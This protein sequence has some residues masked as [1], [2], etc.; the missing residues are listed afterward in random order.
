MTKHAVSHAKQHQR[1]LENPTTRKLLKE[2]IAEWDHLNLVQRGERLK[3]L[4]KLRCTDH[5][6]AKA[7]RQD[8]RTISR[9]LRIA[10]LP[11]EQRAK[12]ARGAS[13]AQFLRQKKLKQRIHG[14]RGNLADKNRPKPGADAKILPLQNEIAPL[15]TSVRQLEERV[16]TVENKMAH[17]SLPGQAQVSSSDQP[18][19]VPANVEGSQPTLQ[20]LIRALQNQKMDALDDHWKKLKETCRPRRPV[21][22]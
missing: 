20:E 4:K 22:I 12:I 19:G 5:G 1:A 18:V 21:L 2:L 16:S 15:I 3:A 11:A 8:P 10:D 9:D 14:E 7:L 13:A 17:A 6:L